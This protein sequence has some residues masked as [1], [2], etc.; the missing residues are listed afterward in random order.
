MVV[1][2]PDGPAANI[3]GQQ[4]FSSVPQNSVVIEVWIPG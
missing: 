3:D 2:H 4:A 1:I